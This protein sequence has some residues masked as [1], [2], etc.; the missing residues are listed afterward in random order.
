MTTKTKSFPKK[1]KIVEVEED[2][3][4]PP[5]E[6]RNATE[7]VVEETPKPI[8]K[9]VNPFVSNN[10]SRM[11]PSMYK[12]VRSRKDRKTG[13]V[14][15][16]VIYMIKAEDIIFD[17]IK[18]INRKIRYIPGEAYI[19]E[20]EQK[21]DAK[22]K[23]PIIFNDGLLAVPPQNPTLK[24]F[25]DHCNQNGDNPNRIKTTKPAFMMVN[26]KK[27]AKKLIQK[28]SQELDAM[29]L[30]LKMPIEKLVG[31]AKVLGVNVEK[32]TEEI[33]YDMKILAKRSPSS[34]ISGMDDPKTAIKET[35]I[36][37]KEHGII[38]IDKNK[39]SWKRG[40]AKTLI[41]HTPIG[42]DSTDHFVDYCMDGDGELVL[43]EI[44]RQI[45]S[46]N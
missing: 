1:G 46:F 21:K 14:M 22:V 34:F 41:T 36:N 27:D 38:S 28:E 2:I 35:I 4:I 15:Y 26:K 44:K 24:N 19:Y 40:G 6:E 8:K 23:A 32:S 9:V 33:R 25:L 37:A 30:A 5:Y 20:D 29:Q 31:Y 42:K 17:P 39:I 16:P 45:K 12:L 7:P 3:N 11:K 18:G 10:A 13:K 43:D